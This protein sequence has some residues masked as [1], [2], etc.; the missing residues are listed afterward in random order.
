MSDTFYVR[1][2]TKPARLVFYKQKDKFKEKPTNL[3]FLSFIRELFFV[4]FY[5]TDQLYCEQLRNGPNYD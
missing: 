4:G 2:P 5:V 3:T 1:G